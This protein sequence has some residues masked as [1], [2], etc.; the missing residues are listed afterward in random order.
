MCGRVGSSYQNLARLV[1]TLE[2]ADRYSPVAPSLSH[3][4]ADGQTE[5]GHRAGDKGLADRHHGA[6]LP[7]KRKHEGQLIHGLFLRQT[8]AC[9]DRLNY[10]RD[11]PGVKGIKGTEPGFLAPQR[12]RDEEVRVEEE[13]RR[14]WRKISSVSVSLAAAGCG[15]T[16]KCPV[17]GH[18]VTC[19]P[20]KLRLFSDRGLGGRDGEKGGILTEIKQSD[21]PFMNSRLSL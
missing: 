11:A 9:T 7:G 18:I 20:Y 3:H 10:S 13:Q 4:W 15:V 16:G 2:S 21:P 8:D 6:H 5:R 1:F 14:L 17:K 19:V 12:E